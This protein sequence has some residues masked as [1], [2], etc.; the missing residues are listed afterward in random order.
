MSTGLTTFKTDTIKEYVNKDK[1]VGIIII[2]AVG[3]DNHL[4]SG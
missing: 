2:R 1:S 3:L 4:K